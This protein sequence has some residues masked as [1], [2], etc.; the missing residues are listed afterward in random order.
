MELRGFLRRCRERCLWV[1][2]ECGRDDQAIMTNRRRDIFVVHT[3]QRTVTTHTYI[4]GY[5]CAV[6]SRAQLLRRRTA[7]AVA[8]SS[9]SPK[10]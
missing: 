5:H 3:I 2:V 7:W 10:P 9:Q 1:F 4:C 6:S 8:A